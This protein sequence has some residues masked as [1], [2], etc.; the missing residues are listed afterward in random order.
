[1]L[2]LFFSYTNSAKLRTYKDREIIIDLGFC[3]IFQGLL[4]HKTLF[5]YRNKRLTMFRYVNIMSI[6]EI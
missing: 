5:I 1:M 2:L 6:L 3:S 4:F